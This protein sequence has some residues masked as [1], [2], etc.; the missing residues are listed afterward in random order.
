VSVG[1]SYIS[2]SFITTKQNTMKKKNVKVCLSRQTILNLLPANRQSQL[3][4]GISGLRC[5]D[6]SLQRSCYPY[7]CPV[8]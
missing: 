4:G 5:D 3:K 2:R 7:V 6:L 1:V 8:M